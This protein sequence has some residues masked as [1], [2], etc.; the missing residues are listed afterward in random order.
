MIHS[1][2]RFDMRNLIERSIGYLS[3]K[4]KNTCMYEKK[5][6]PTHR[7][8]LLSANRRDRSEQLFI[9]IWCRRRDSN[10]HGSDPTRS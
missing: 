10:S 1:P 6:A 2:K 9:N 7:S 3:M 5:I 4:P 8:A